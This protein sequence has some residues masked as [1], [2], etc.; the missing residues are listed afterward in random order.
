MRFDYISL[1]HRAT[2]SKLGFNCNHVDKGNI[3]YH[4]ALNEIVHIRDK[5]ASKDI[6]IYYD[7]CENKLIKKQCLFKG[8]W[9]CRNN[10]YPKR[11]SKLMSKSENRELL[12]GRLQMI[13]YTLTNNI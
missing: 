10:I 8:I 11:L 7:V 1:T 12:I 2:L 13:I 6:D 3:R 9:T 4:E 5:V